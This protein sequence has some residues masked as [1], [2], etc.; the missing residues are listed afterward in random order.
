MVASR[1]LSGVLR[2]TLSLE[3]EDG[4]SSFP[5][6]YFDDIEHTCK[7]KAGPYIKIYS[8]K[9]ARC[10]SFWPQLKQ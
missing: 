3:K 1:S 2:G 8:S 4:V 5:Q 9:E 6:D 7:H 10:S